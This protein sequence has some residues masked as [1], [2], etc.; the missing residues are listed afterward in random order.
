MKAQGVR[1][2]QQHNQG[3]Y[4][5]SLYWGAVHTTDIHA[6]HAKQHD[7]VTPVFRCHELTMNW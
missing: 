4:A 1:L 3:A 7:V 2:T 6:T 5:A